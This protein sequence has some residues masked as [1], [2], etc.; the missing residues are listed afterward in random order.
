MALADL[1]AENTVLVLNGIGEITDWGRTDP[2]FNIENIDARGNLSR[3]F[4][5]NAAAF[6]RKNP[7]IR[8]TLNL[9][10]GSPQALSIQAQ[11]NSRTEVSGTYASIDGLEGAVFAEGI[12]VNGKSIGRGGPGMND[13]TFVIECNTGVIQ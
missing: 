2:P 6:H 10:P 5:G 9:M 11:V 12:F 7:G 8:I 4:G 13:A 3:G 1:S